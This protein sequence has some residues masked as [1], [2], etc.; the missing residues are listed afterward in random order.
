[1]KY[2]VVVLVL[3]FFSACSMKSYDITQTKIIIIKSPKMKFADIGYLRNS[4]EAI[5]LEMFIA[6][7]PIEKISINHL[8]C[9]S[10]GCLSKSA[11]NQ[12]YLHYSYP[13]AILQNILLGRE[14]YEGILKVKTIDGFEQKIVNDN[15]DIKYRVNNKEIFFKDK[16]NKIIFKIKDTK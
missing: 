13:D 12:E 8:I 5:E 10:A 15:V 14:I 2:I 7:H 11:F 6:G 16:K 1:M 3:L 9:V 4:D